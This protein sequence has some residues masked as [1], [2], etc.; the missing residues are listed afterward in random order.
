MDLNLEYAAHQKALISAGA[1]ENDGDRAVQLAEAEHIAGR[2]GG[3]QHK[4]GAAAACAWSKAMVAGD[5]SD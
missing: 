5:K 4:L 1:A 3:F 2:I